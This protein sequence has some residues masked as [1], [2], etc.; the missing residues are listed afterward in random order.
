MGQAGSGGTGPATNLW[1]ASGGGWSDR[2]FKT[3]LARAKAQKQEADIAVKIEKMQQEMGT[4]DPEMKA[5]LS[6]MVDLQ[7]QNLEALH[8]LNQRSVSRNAQST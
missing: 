8:S 4:A 3:Q 7:A 5:L 2:Q 1:K 6:R